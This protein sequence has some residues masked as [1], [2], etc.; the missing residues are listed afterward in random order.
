[1]IPYIAIMLAAYTIARLVLLTFPTLDDSV[2]LGV[3]IAAIAAIAYGLIYIL[4]A[5]F[6][7]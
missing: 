7:A 3:G 1:M 2:K 6:G 4:S 5:G